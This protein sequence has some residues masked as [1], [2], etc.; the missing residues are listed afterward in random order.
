MTCKMHVRCGRF[1]V[2]AADSQAGFAMVVINYITL[3]QMLKTRMYYSNS[4]IIIIYF[5]S[6]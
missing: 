2:N 5:I 3:I 6:I 4:N 1:S